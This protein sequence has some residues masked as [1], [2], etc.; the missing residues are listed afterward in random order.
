MSKV[1][2]Y[3]SIVAQ[4]V[5]KIT[6]EP[7]LFIIGIT[8]LLVAIVLTGTPL[9]PSEL[10]FIVL[11]IAFLAVIGIVGYY[12]SKALQVRAG[13]NTTKWTADVLSSEPAGAS[14][15][16]I[17]SDI[18][19]Y[20]SRPGF[21]RVDFSENEVSGA[22]GEVAVRDDK[23]P[24]GGSQ[25]NAILDVLRKN[26]DGYFHIWLKSYSY[27]EGKLSLIPKKLDMLGKRRIRAQCQARVSS[28]SEHELNLIIKDPKDPQGKYLARVR[29]TLTSEAWVPIDEVFE[30]SPYH[31]CA[32]RFQ[33]EKVSSAPS[34]VQVRSFILTEREE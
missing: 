17:P 9:G 7:L 8:T 14:V 23:Y 16:Q 12:A 31:D 10:H 6:N 32:F 21:D 18:T 1:A 15:K 3:Q 20:D 34:H 19:L 27:P 28:G 25:K 2:S 11:V 29:R 22:V 30:I 4:V 24:N 13:P 5:A 26:T 33:D